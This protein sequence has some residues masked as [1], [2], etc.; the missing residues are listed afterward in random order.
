MNKDEKE[1][2]Q[3]LEKYAERSKQFTIND[4]ASVTGLPVLETEY[5]IK[6]MMEKYDC[7]LKVTESGNLIYDFGPHLQRRDAKSFGEYFNDFLAWIWRAFS[8]MYKFMIS[9]F[10]VVYFVVF[11]VIVL[12]IVIAVMSG[13]K[14]DN[15]K[16]VGNL[17]YVLFRVF[18]SI[19]EWNTIM[20]YNNTYRRKDSYGYTYKHYTEKEGVLASMR[21]KGDSQDKKGFVASIYDFVFGPPRVEEHPL[22][23]MQE[24]AT[25]LRE[26]KG[27]VSTY[28]VQ[29]L[30]GWTRDEAQN[31]M[32]QALG[33][34]N[35]KAEISPNAVL[36]GDFTE[37]IRRKDNT[38][39]APIV[40]YWDEYE[41]EYQLTGNKFWRNASI[42]AMNAFNLL[43]SSMV[44]W[45]PLQAFASVP[46]MEIFLGWIPFAY[47]FVFFLIPAVRWIFLQPK[48]R[49][50]HLVNVRK[51][52]M[53]AI[54]AEESAQMTLTKLTEIANKQNPKE[55][56]LNK[57]LVEKV[58][59][60]VIYDL[61]GESFVD[62][63]GEVIYKFERLDQELEE[64]EKIRRE[65][66]DDGGL[67]KIVFE[68]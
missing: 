50:Q 59:M 8:I 68:A 16:G 47:S 38:E 44:L 37:L 11:L 60:D 53:M 65:K 3:V 52:L 10:L 20:G 19:F 18:W 57:Q 40:Y 63:N 7:K 12:G 61:E 23:N 55:E 4:A 27:L 45:G 42:F 46:A 35:G 22:A 2:V 33:S 26:N 25:F 67:G 28:E 41:P 24:L 49:K 5:A 62:N 29:A 6:D 56:K 34:F 1:Y 66:R 43:L 30:A 58:M 31:F 32:T 64:I 14:G 36:Y 51:R 15:S 17:V 13:G 39:G 21:G 54:Y 9:A 48:R